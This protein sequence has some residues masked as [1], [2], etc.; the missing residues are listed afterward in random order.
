MNNLIKDLLPQRELITFNEEETVASALQKLAD[1]HILSAPVVQSQTG[2]KTDVVGFADV[3]D[4]LAFLAQISTRIITDPVFGESRHL[5]F[6]DWRILLKR[7][8]DFTLGQVREVIDL[9]RRNPFKQLKDD[10]TLRDAIDLFKNRIHRI[11]VFGGGDL[12]GV[13]SQTDVLNYV[14]NNRDKFPNLR[15]D[16]PLQQRVNFN[17]VATINSQESAID[18][19]LKIH[20]SVVSAIAIVN[21]QKEM[22]GVLSAADVEFAIESDF[23]ALLKPVREFVEEIRAKQNKSSDYM[24][25]CEPN[26][27]FNEA[28]SLLNKEKVHRLFVLDEMKRPIGVVTLT[29]FLNNI[30]QFQGPAVSR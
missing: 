2:E 16:E 29:D 9:S 26:A 24:V 13:L 21:D 3:L 28:L 5:K 15:L 23:I 14:A 1:N 19:F 20:E 4:F 30:F 10:A 18:A 25:A 7:K 27:K 6:D 22:I 11:A 12:L 17:Q 8:K